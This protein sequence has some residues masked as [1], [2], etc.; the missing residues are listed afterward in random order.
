MVFNFVLL[1]TVNKNYVQR[2]LTLILMQGILTIW[3]YLN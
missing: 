3:L 2:L 1:L